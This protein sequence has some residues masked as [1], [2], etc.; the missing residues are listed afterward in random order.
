MLPSRFLRREPSRL[1][2]TAET[3]LPD[4]GAL[5]LFLAVRRGRPLDHEAWRGSGAENETGPHEVEG[6]G[7]GV[8]AKREW[9]PRLACADTAGFLRMMSELSLSGWSILGGYG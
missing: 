4:R 2:S 7:A 1:V 3:R 8:D 5:R 9:L 6:V